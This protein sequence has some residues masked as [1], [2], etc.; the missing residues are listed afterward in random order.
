MN[1]EHLHRMAK[2]AFDVLN[3]ARREG[4][5][6]DQQLEQVVAGFMV[7]LATFQQEDRD[8]ELAQ[9]NYEYESR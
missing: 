8:E 1:D 9:L 4:F 6:Q 5:K 2:T 7:D 3:W